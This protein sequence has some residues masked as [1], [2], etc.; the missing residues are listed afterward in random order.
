MLAGIGVLGWL[1]LAAPSAE[2]VDAALGRVVAAGDYQTEFPVQADAAP[3]ET[4]AGTARAEPRPARPETGGG[5]RTLAGILWWLLVGILALVALAWAARVWSER[6]HLAPDPVRAESAAAAPDAETGPPGE[7]A[8]T[9]AAAG[10]Y[11]DAIHA[12]LLALLARRGGLH[13][14]WTS[15]EALARLRLQPPAREALG[16]IVALVERTLFG[17]CPATRADYERA[18]SRREAAS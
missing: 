2:A 7:D 6:R 11:S 9:L 4:P 15:R 5:L 12:L 17:G 3:A 1:L 18:R 8:D 10:R 16:E 13:P 14:A